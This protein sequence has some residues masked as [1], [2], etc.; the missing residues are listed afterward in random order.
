MGL[1]RPHQLLAETPA[2]TRQHTCISHPPATAPPHALQVC[3]NARGIAG[4][5][6]LCGYEC[7][8]VAG[9][10]HQPIST[11]RASR[12]SRRELVTPCRDPTLRVTIGRHTHLDRLEILQC[13]DIRRQSALPRQLP[14]VLRA[15]AKHQPSCC[16]RG[17]AM[18]T[19]NTAARKRRMPAAGSFRRGEA[20]MR[21]QRRGPRTVCSAAG[22]Q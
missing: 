5:Q 18:L 19:R 21:A 4:G 15:I 10:C 2:A 17:C 14:A 20:E 3:G 13:C 6:G 8:H 16:Q 7:I 11:P 12:T 1:S 9:G 22:G